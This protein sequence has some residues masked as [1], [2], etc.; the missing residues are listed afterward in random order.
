MAR[1]ENSRN[2]RRTSR[3]HRRSGSFRKQRRVMQPEFREDVLGG[4]FLKVMRFTHQQW[5]D[6]LRWSLYVLIC[7]V[8]LV[9]QDVIMSRIHLLGTTT[10]LA[11]GIIL[12]ITVMTGTEVGSVFVLISSVIYYFSGSSPGPYTV[13]LMTTIGIAVTMFRQQYLHR[14]AGSII[15]GTGL[16]LVAYEIGVYAVGIFLGLT[17]WD[18]IPAF[19]LT[20]VYTTLVMYPLYYLINRIGQIGG[21]TWKE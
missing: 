5:M 12:L 10:D 13:A 1:Q 6:L 20:A 14:S 7:I 19:L 16:A 15:A 17:R 21:H 18:R 4:G 2:R 9:V 8:C 3:P 11:A